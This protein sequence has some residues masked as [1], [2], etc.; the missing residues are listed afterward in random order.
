MIG[1]I[2]TAVVV[3]VWLPVEEPQA[4]IVE[5]RADVIED[6]VEQHRHSGEM[7]NVDDAFKLVRPRPQIIDFQRRNTLPR[8]E[9]IGLLQIAGEFG[10][11]GDM[12][13]ELRREEVQTIITLDGIEG[14]TL[15]RRTLDCV[16]PNRV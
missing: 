13:I 9:S 15:K 6:K 3:A 11:I 10:I 16:R 7:E 2:K 4:L 1:A 12:V 8:Q 14:L 5:A